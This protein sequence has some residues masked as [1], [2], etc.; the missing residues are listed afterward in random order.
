MMRLGT[1]WPA[2]QAPPPTV[3]ELLRA[4]IAAVEAQHG[5]QGHWTLTWLEGRAIAE[6]DIGWE[7]RVDA[8]GEVVTRAF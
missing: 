6:W 7:V 5:T 4:A 8:S 3:P 1:R 2:G